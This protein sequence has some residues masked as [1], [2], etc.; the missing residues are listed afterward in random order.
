MKEVLHL[1]SLRTVNYS[2]RHNILSAF[3]LER[4]PMSFLTPAGNGREASRRRAL[5][6]PMGMV[7]CVADIRP[8]RDIHPISAP[9]ML[10]PLQSLRC[11]PLKSSLAM[12]LAES[13]GSLLRE[14]QPDAVLWHFIEQ[15]VIALD[16]LPDNRIANFHITCLTRLANILGIWPDSTGFRMGMVFDLIDARFRHSAPTHP[17]FIAGS[18]AAMVALLPRLTYNNMYRLRLTRIQRAELLDAVLHYYTLHYAP[19]DSLKST[20]VLRALF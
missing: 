15:S 3:T 18:R 4:G 20:D 16:S 13:L 9:R 11:S 6:M 2:D 8:G 5:L 19:L 14:A 1:I 17:E 7:E 10:A 12:F